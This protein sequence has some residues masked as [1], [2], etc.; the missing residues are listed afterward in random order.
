VLST[1]SMEAY[2]R[3]DN[4]FL[5]WIVIANLIQD[6]A[7]FIDLRSRLPII[8]INILEFA[9]QLRF[10]GLIRL[11]PLPFAIRRNL[12]VIIFIF[13]ITSIVFTITRLDKFCVCVS[14]VLTMCGS[15]SFVRNK[16]LRLDRSLMLESENGRRIPY[17]EDTLLFLELPRH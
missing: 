6:L 16:P 1:I 11:F 12:P 9:A 8:H 13:A 15:E 3:K 14:C 7:E 4:N 17:T 10:L 5:R 2:L